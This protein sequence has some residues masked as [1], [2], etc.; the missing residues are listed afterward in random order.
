MLKYVNYDIVFQ[1]IPDEVTL[2]IYISNCP[3]RCVGCHSA[4]LRDDIGEVLDTTALSRIV[5]MYEDAITCICFMGGD[6]EPHEVCRLA[7]YI[8]SIY[9]EKYSLA[10]YS[11]NSL[12]PEC[13]DTGY[14]R[15][16]KLG[17][18]IERLGG[19]KSR[20]TNQKFYKLNKEE[21]TLEDITYIFWK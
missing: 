8:N 19:L 1:E 20:K 16:L 17:P 3:N 9:G 5:Q 21:G 2:A 13:F 6:S 12:I 11:G 15:Y 18:Y 7:S 10:W 4:L 14:F